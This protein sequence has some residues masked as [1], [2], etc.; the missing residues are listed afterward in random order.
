MLIHEISASEGAGYVGGSQLL[1]GAGILSCDTYQGAKNST[2]IKSCWATFV[3]KSESVNSRTSL[4]NV[5]AVRHDRIRSSFIVVG[6]HWCVCS[7][8]RV[9]VKGS[10]VVEHWLVQHCIS[11]LRKLS[12]KTVKQRETPNYHELLYNFFCRNRILIKSTINNKKK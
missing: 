4:A 9:V 3:A 1:N 8:K 2:K 7:T 10:C 6:S 11:C 5:S 12:E